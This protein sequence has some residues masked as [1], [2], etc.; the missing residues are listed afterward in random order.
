MRFETLR[1]NR[2]ASRT[3]FHDFQKLAPDREVEE[4]I[5]KEMRDWMRYRFSWQYKA[6]AIALLLSRFASSLLLIV[7]PRPEKR[8]S[9]SKGDHSS[10]PVISMKPGNMP[11]TI[12]CNTSIDGSHR[13][14][15]EDSTGAPELVHDS[16]PAFL[17]SAADGLQFPTRSHYQSWRGA[18]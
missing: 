15:D 2:R 1:Q 13:L 9:A 17:R 6:S 8:S 12:T 7:P 11:V 4:V 5:E 16:K 14:V 10:V 3:T 18:W